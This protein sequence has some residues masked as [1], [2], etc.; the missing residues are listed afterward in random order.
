VE[1]TQDTPQVQDPVQEPAA[2]PAQE[3]TTPTEAP[4]QA[5]AETVQEPA[6]SEE[7]APADSTV[8]APAEEE[9]AYSPPPPIPAVAPIDFSQLPVDENNLI[10]PNALASQINQRIAQAEQNAAA[11]AQQLYAEQE[12]E[13]RQ[14]DKAYEKYPDLKNNKEMRDLVHNA[15]L[16]KVTELLSSNS[17]PSSI[18]LPTPAQVADNLFKYVGQA[19]TEG[20][21]QANQ[22]T[23][24]QKSGVLETA[25]RRSNDAVDAVT[26]ARANINNPN[27]QLANKARSM[28]LHRYLTG[29]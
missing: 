10:D 14:W 22:N 7:S 12:S 2:T 6:P 3:P 1:N 18:K 26:E 8:V 29:E 27:K 11:R 15:R 21:Q 28:L 5:P 20:M 16:G 13:K 17:D 23:Q 4:V 24:V 25:S 19:K 9:E